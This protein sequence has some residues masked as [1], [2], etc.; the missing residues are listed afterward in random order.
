MLLQWSMEKYEFM[1]Q[2]YIDCISDIVNN[3]E[4]RFNVCFEI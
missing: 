3:R 2:K 1:L 4:I